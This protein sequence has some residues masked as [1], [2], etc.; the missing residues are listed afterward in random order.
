MQA[1]SARTSSSSATRVAELLILGALFLAGCGRIGFDGLD[2]GPSGDSARPSV[3]AASGSLSFAGLC[4]FES[5]V[6]VENGI[7]VDDDVGQRLSEAVEAGCASAIASRAVSQDNASAV[8]A[9]SGRP[10]TPATELVILGGGD[11]P[12]RVVRYL[13]QMDTPLI[14]GGSPTATL[15]ERVSGRVI[16]EGTTDLSNDFIFLQVILE[17]IGGTISLS[18][19]GFRENGTVAAAIYFENVV[20]PGIREENASWIVVRWSDTDATTGPSAGDTFT[21]VESG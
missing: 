18:G 3:D 20:G 5:H 8:D 11:G 14:W 6:I 12:H 13:L 2:S 1:E 16:V 15:T 10:L 4:D 19:Q 21:L 9:D 7:A 17:P